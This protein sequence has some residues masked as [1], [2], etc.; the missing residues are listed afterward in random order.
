MADPP[1][2]ALIDIYMPEMNGQEAA[3]RIWEAL[4]RDA[5]KVVAVSA[6]TLDHERREFLE[7]GFDAF[8]PK[9]FRAEDI[10]G[11]L[12]EQ[13]GVEFEYASVED[14]EPKPLPDLQDIDLP[15]DL[16]EG[17]SRAAEISNVTELETILT[18]AE[19][20]GE[21]EARLAAHLR[22]LSQDFKMDEILG[23]LDKIKA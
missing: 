9:P 5:L 10:Y 2:I 3:L 13:L 17:L 7:L 14:E 18:D 22:T 12:A 8:I 21:N 6:S 19:R 20:L 16:L 4:G 1:D 23:I 15:A 11:C